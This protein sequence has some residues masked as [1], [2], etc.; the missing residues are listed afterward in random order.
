MRK[1]EGGRSGSRS[2]CTR[3]GKVNGIARKENLEMRQEGRTL[4]SVNAKGI[5]ERK[6]LDESIMAISQPVP[7]TPRWFAQMMHVCVQ[8]NIYSSHR[9]PWLACYRML[10]LEGPPSK[11]PFF[12]LFLPPLRGRSLSPGFNLSISLICRVALSLRMICL[13]RSTKA[14]S[15]FRLALADVS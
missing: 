10:H 6:I 9:H 1:W 3:S 14:S 7:H 13:Q 15:T 12:F 11:T 5:F 2:L 8:S 4:A